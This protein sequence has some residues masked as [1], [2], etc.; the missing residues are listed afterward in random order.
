MGTVSSE[1][2]LDGNLTLEDEF[3]GNSSAASFIREAYES[4]YSQDNSATQPRVWR[5]EGAIPRASIKAFQGARAAQFALPPRGLADH[6]VD[7]FFE[8]VFYLYPVFHRPSFESAYR[9][10]WEPATGPTSPPRE[11]SATFVG[12]GGSVN[13][14][15]ESPVFHCA[16]NAIFALGC[17]FSDLPGLNRDS[18]ALTFFLRCKTLLGVEF[19]ESNTTGV[20]QVLLIMTLYLQST[21]FPGRC[22]KSIGIACRLAQGM[23]LHIKTRSA[24]RSPLET[25]MRRR[26]WQGCVVLDM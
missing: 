21:P 4:F 18:T 15:H 11:P 13:T 2:G 20:V 14:G 10:L 7:R 17:H 6:L 16:L 19:L 8:R 5:A 1:D 22:W 12:L 25:D 26:I 23:G 24:E 9:R 3:Y